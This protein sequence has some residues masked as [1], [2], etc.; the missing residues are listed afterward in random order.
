MLIKPFKAQLPILSKIQDTDTFFEEA[1]EEYTKYL[2]QGC[3]RQ[4]TEVAFFIYS[5]CFLFKINQEPFYQLIETRPEVAM[6]FIK[7]L[8]KRLRQLNDKTAQKGG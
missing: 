6:G 4:T 8:S 7:I 5:C 3:F 1:K 2:H